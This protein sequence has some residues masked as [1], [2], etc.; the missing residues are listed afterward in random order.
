MTGDPTEHAYRQVVQE[1]DFKRF[2]V[3]LHQT[4][5][6]IRARRDLTE[7]AYALVME[8]RARIE[9]WAED[10]P[11]FYTS[12]EPL[13]PSPL[14]LSPVKEMLTAGQ[15]AEVGPMAAVAGAM[16]EY[17]GQRLLNHSSTI[18]VENGGDVFIAADRTITIGLFS[19]NS[20]LSMRLGL[21][22]TPDRTPAGVCTS[23]GAIGHS[24]SLGRTDAATVVA[25]HTALADAA[26]TGLGNRI[27]EVKDIQPALEW[28]LSIPGVRG[29]A[30]VM[31]EQVGL[32]GDL[33]LVAL[34]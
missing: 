31:G 3:R 8:G 1:G 20:P 26:A 7:Q 24:L 12:L 28:V 5:L 10:H 21:T 15:N 34:T 25:D 9:G 32:L 14:A 2:R 27:F 33:E 29:A 16:A 22:L 17:V 6:L 18:I 19:G 4:D 13:P 11:G 23:S 30:V